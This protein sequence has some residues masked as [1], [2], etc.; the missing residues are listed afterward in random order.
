MCENYYKNE[1]VFE[2]DVAELLTRVGWNKEIIMYP[3]EEDLIENWRKIL[4]RNNKSID[5]LNNQ[6][7][8]KT[9][10]DKVLNEVRNKRTPFNLNGFINGTSVSIIRDN[11]NDPEHLGK[12]VSLKIY[13][14]HEI[15]GGTSTYQ[16]VRQP[17]FKARDDVAPERRGDLMLLIN[18]M[19]VFHIELKKSGIPISKATYQIQ[20]YSNEGV[21]SGIFSLIQIFVAMTPEDVL[22]FANPGPDTKVF[23][24]KFFFHW[25]NVDNIPIT[26]FKEFIRDFL[27][28]PMAHELIGFYTIADKDDNT[29]K[30]LRSYQY[31][32][33][34]RIRRVAYNH[35]WSSCYQRGGLIWHT[36]G[37]GKTLTSFKCADLIAKLGF[38]D[39]VVFLVDRTTLDVQS[40][41]NYRNFA[42]D[43]DSVQNVETTSSLITK[44]KSDESSHTLIVA[45]IQKMSRIYDD[46]LGRIDDDIEKIN[47]KKIIFIVDECHRDTFGLMMNKI[48][49][50]FPHA[51]FFGF[52]GTPIFEKN[53]KKGNK[54]SDV[55]GNELHRY[56]IGDG[57][58][59]NNVLGFDTYRVD[60]YKEDEIRRVVAEQECK[61][62]IEDLKA[63][64]DQQAIKKYYKIINEM[65][66]LKVEEYLKSSQYKTEKYKNGVIDHI[67]SKFDNISRNNKF[68][69]IFATSSIPEAFEY[70]D[71]LKSRKTNL[72]FT[73][74]VDKNE[75]NTAEDALMGIDQT[76][77]EKIAEIIRDYNNMYKMSFSW[78]TYGDMKS[79][80]SL[81]LAHK[82]PYT[83][84]SKNPDERLDLVIVVN[85][86]LTG[87]DSKWVN[88]LYLDKLLEQENLIQAISRTNRIFDEEKPF[89][90][91]YYYRKPY[92]MEQNMQDALDTYSGEK[93]YEVFVPKLIENIRRLN[94]IYTDIKGLFD[95]EGI[96]YFRYVPREDKDKS[97][98]ISLFNALTR[99]VIKLRIQDFKWEQKEYYDEKTDKN[100]TVLMSEEEY[101]ILCIRYAEL[102]KE[103]I[104]NKSDDT[105]FEIDTA[106]T[107]IQV[108]KIDNDYMNARFDRFK[109]INFSKEEQ[110][111]IDTALAEVFAC[112]KYLTEEE[113]RFAQMVISDVQNGELDV[114]NQNTLRDYITEYASREQNKTIKDFADTFGLNYE[115]LK[116]LVSMNSE[117]IADLNILK[118]GV[119]INK[120]I[121]YI[122]NKDGEIL[123]PLKAKSKLDSL[124]REF[125][126]TGGDSFKNKE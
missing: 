56:T 98:F 30:V 41:E 99:T 50:T 42:D 13:D 108:A 83:G 1:L 43:S 49:E 84:I 74:I 5:K 94:V 76:K 3:T 20:K 8:T 81:R 105:P 33:V 106:I 113:Q 69:A 63:R 109:K 68:H 121:E 101:K 103:I 65:N 12:T 95:S 19:P 96:E 93:A 72:K 47:K 28:I 53:S 32:A 88:V 71:I 75:D 119:D 91:V 54:S 122:K 117:N 85:Q 46:G 9:E 80:V 16:I 11:P 55:F 77:G 37:S 112:F 39:K 110:E 34:N 111:V 61:G 51:L 64:G 125:I 67:L 22:Y 102:M 21:F 18:G 115:S 2:N 70:Y 29:L 107:T 17:R 14:R 25:G 82:A 26:N 35:D 124:I 123:T 86:M 73:V 120:T 31:Y 60:I 114:N 40:Y 66:M 97:Q 87:Y 100:V 24:E 126:K 48:K 92:T 38:S 59:D 27:S 116:K 58:R 52:S 62:T 4:S 44:L 90:L 7:L 10:M 89:G 15:A 45:S 6:E 104:R 79:D 23:N 36:T 78:A 57:I 118:Q